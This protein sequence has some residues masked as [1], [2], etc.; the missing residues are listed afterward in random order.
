MKLLLMKKSHVEKGFLQN[1]DSKISPIFQ[2]QF[3]KKFFA[4][5]KWQ[6]QMFLFIDSLLMKMILNFSSSPYKIVAYEI[7][8]IQKCICYKIFV[9]IY[10]NFRYIAYKFDTYEKN[11]QCQVR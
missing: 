6:F 1:G 5:N 4:E 7:N 11:R 2:F 9:E 3:H 10:A 8:S